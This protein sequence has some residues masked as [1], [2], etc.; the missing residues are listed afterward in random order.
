MTTARQGFSRKASWGHALIDR[1]L[2]LPQ[3]W[4]EDQARRAKTVVPE[5][6]RFKT[7][8]EI[9]RDLII[10]AL[11][12]GVPCAFVLGDALYGSDRKLRRMLQAR[13]QKSGSRHQCG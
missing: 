5:E 1:R 6:V 11:D 2:Y 7:K 12:A 9:A 10:A 8:P 3:S 13:Q 4:A